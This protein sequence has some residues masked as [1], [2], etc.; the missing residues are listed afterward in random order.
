MLTATS[1]RYLTLL[2]KFGG[3][4]PLR[5][6]VEVTVD[7]LAAAWFCTLRNAKLLVRKL[8]DERLIEWQAGRGRGNRSRLTF[9]AEREP[10]L[11]AAAQ[12]MAKGGEYKTA[13]EWLDAYGANSQAKDRFV[14]WL[15]EHF[16]YASERGEY[17]QSDVLRFPVNRP[18]VSLDPADLHL[19]FDAHMVRQLFDRLVQYDVAGEECVPGLAH[20][21]KRN[22]DATEWTFY[23]RKGIRFHHGRE[24]TPDDVRF[25]LERVRRS[26]SHGWLLRE[27]KEV[28]VEGPR[29]VVVRLNKPNYIF[30]RYVGYVSMSILPRELVEQDE[31]RFWRQPVGSGP[32]RVVEWT[33][34]RFVMEA[35]EA[36]YLGRPHLDRVEIAFLP[37]LEITSALSSEW[38]QLLRGTSLDSRLPQSG[39]EKLE[40][41]S[42]GCTLLTWNAW[43]DG[44]HRSLAFR[45]AMEHIIDREALIREIG[46]DRLH[47]AKG[48]HPEYGGDVVYKE[49][50]EAEARRLLAEAGYAGETV[51]IA[52]FPNHAA[53]A[54]WI[55]RRCARFGVKLDVRYLAFKDIKDE[56]MHASVDGILCC[57]TIAENE[58]CEIENYEQSNNFVKSHLGPDIR[59]WLRE[60]IDELLASDDPMA[61]RIHLEK[62]EAR[63]REEAHAMFLWH[64]KFGTYVHPEVKGVELN[65]FGW[66]DF[67]FIWLEAAASL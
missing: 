29:T 50:S 52:S 56:A 33:E 17:E 21:W 5:R 43:R 2:N 23:L 35:H 13:F 62:V 27:L 60:R 9:L 58:V 16:G 22:E 14:A 26:Y 53:E 47:P 34:E 44:P 40:R 1:E 31:S 48:F 66:M 3:E 37:E 42:A 30:P 12:R 24:V 25:T 67:K 49:A 54:E 65:S 6:P 4:Q 18:I 7:E 63:L 64:R 19:S 59:V 39:W 11:L 20:A 57:I 38:E 32:F 8:R 51:A 41:I 36:Y 10:M 61:R 28:A 45:Q 55:Q 15:G 46:A